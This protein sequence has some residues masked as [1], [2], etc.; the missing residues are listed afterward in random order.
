M[1]PTSYQMIMPLIGVQEAMAA[2]QTSNSQKSMSQAT[3]ARKKLSKKSITSPTSSNCGDEFLQKQYLSSNASVKRQSKKN[4]I[5]NKTMTKT[6]GIDIAKVDNDS[7][8]LDEVMSG[9]RGVRSVSEMSLL[10][11]LQ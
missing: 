6:L 10:E 9:G 1:I 7:Q 5:L 8:L 3:V 11:I 2:A 4:S